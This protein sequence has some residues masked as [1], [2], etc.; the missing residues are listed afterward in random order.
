VI[1]TDRAAKPALL[2]ETLRAETI[3]RV[4][5]FTRTKHGADKVVKSLAQGGITAEALHGNKSQNQRDRVMTN[6]RSGRITTLVATDIAARGIDV[7]GI[8]HVINYDLPNIPES[9][10]HRIGR[11]A[12]AGAEGI[13]ISFC[14]QE[15]GSFLRDIE[16]LIRMAIPASGNVP[17]PHGERRSQGQPNRSSQGRGNRRPDRSRGA[18]GPGAGNRGPRETSHGAGQDER[19]SRP[20]QP[21]GNRNPE[22]DRAAAAPD[23]QDGGPNK[24]RRRR[25]RNNGGGASQGASHGAPEGSSRGGHRGGQPAGDYNGEIGSI[26]FL[27]RSRATISDAASGAGSAPANS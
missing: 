26:G 23:R 3:E 20:P 6:F 10:V 11:T 18:A 1:H 22:Q 13:A 14:D 24:G 25:R 8:S 2:L 27:K 4:L 21:R 12:R 17:A 5:V 15:E 9:Y 16:R 19:P 7:T